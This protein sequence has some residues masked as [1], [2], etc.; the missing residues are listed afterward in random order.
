MKTHAG[1]RYRLELSV[2]G[3]G[4]GHDWILAALVARWPVAVVSLSGASPTRAAAV[5]QW[6]GAP[7]AIEI[8]DEVLPQ[9][10]VLPPAALP[11]ELSASV[12]AV[13]ELSRS[14]VGVAARAFSPAL[15]LFAAVSLFGFVVWALARRPS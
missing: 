2:M 8:G 7:G 1:L 13:E 15:A 3:P 5:V 14:A 4:L 11:M 9:N 12:T 6:E 10:G